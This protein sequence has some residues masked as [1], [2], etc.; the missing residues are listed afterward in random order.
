MLRIGQAL[1]P[2]LTHRISK[3]KIFFDNKLLDKLKINHGNLNIFFIEYMKASTQ[4]IE[5]VCEED[6]SLNPILNDADAR[7]KK[8]RAVL[9]KQLKERQMM[10]GQF[11]VNMGGNVPGKKKSTAIQD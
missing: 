9:E 8:L 11:R 10:L 1:S 2:D 6:K 3:V 4:F 5:Q 7:M